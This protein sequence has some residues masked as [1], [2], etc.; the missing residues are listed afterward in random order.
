[1]LAADLE[2][3]GPSRVGWIET[4]Y[5]ADRTRTM[6][7]I[8]AA[9]LALSEHGKENGAVPRQRV[10]E[11]YGLFIKARKPMAAF[12]ARDLAEWEYWDATPDYVALLASNVVADP[13]SRYEIVSY[14]Q[15]SPRAD[16]KAALESLPVAERSLPVMPSQGQ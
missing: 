2:L 10:V 15:R 6:P 13:A 1:M 12:V 14:L 3:R 9:L 8:A 11:A 7:E 16:A 5:L 4:A